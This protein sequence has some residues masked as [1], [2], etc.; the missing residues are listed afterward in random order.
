MCVG[1][2]VRFD[3]KIAC[4]CYGGV[5]IESD[6]LQTV[7]IRSP[8]WRNLTASTERL[9]LLWLSSPTYVSRTCDRQTD[10]YMFRPYGLS[11]RIHHCKCRRGRWCA[12]HR[13]SAGRRQRQ[14]L[15]T[16]AQR[17]SGQKPVSNTSAT[18]KSRLRHIKPLE[19]ASTSERNKCN[20]Q[21]FIASRIGTLNAP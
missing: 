14:R 15:I 3:P 1:E 16:S 10:F 11:H 20:K 6:L 5:I 8:T 7:G 17:A 4:V 2:R 19:H 12:Y 21:S 13:R 9:G 18:P